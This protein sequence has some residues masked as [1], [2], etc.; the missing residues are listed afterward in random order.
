MMLCYLVNRKMVSAE[1]A[2]N[3]FLG[4][5]VADTRRRYSAQIKGGRARRK[6]DGW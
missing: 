3:P 4:N 5:A 2:S 1:T 6:F